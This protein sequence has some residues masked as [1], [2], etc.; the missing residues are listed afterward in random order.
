M[1]IK[2]KITFVSFVGLL[3]L[4]LVSLYLSWSSLQ[5][6]GEAEMV[7]VRATLMS[8]KKEKLK[9]LVESTQAILQSHYE[10][11]HNPQKIAAA[12]QPQLQAI[13]DVTVAAIEAINKESG[14]SIEEKKERAAALVGA[15]RYNG[16]DYLWINDMD[17]QMIMHPIKPALNGKDLSGFADPSG[18]KLFVEFVKVC[19]D[20]GAGTVEY[21]WPKPGAEQPV[22]KL[23]YVKLFEP[24]GWVI[25]TGVYLEAAEER[26]MSDAKAAIGQL[27]YGPEGAEYF[28]INDLDPAMIMHPVKPALDGKNLAGIKDPSGK[29]LFLEMVEK[30]K[31]EQGAGFVDYLWPKPG[32]DEPVA[33]LSFVKLF[34]PWGW[35]VGTGIYLDDVEA[36]VA[37]RQNEITSAIAS[38]RNR[39]IITLGL[40]LVA[41]CG[42]VAFVSWQ[43]TR[44]ISNTSA[45]LEDVAQGEGDLT[46]RLEV[47]SKDEIGQMAGWFNQFIAKLHDIVRNIAEYFET[48]S[49]SANQLLLIS[50]QMDEG[51]REL[52]GQSATVARSADEMSSNM[53]SVAA[54]SEQAATNVSIVAKSMDGMNKSVAE[55]DESA[56]KAQAITTRAV[57]ETNNASVKVKELGSVAAEIGKVTQVITDIS[58]QTNLLALN[59]TIEA[60]RAGDAGKGFA[61]VANEIKELARQTADATKGITEQIDSIQKSTSETVTDIGKIADVITEVDEIVS[62]I[63]ISVEQQAGATAE[64]TENISQ[65]SVGIAEVN[66]NVSQ[67]STFA[68]EIASD[69][70]EVNRIADTISESS[71]QV[72][73]NAKDLSKLAADLQ[74]MIGEF[75]VDRS[76]SPATEFQSGEN[77]ELIAWNDSIKVN[78]S[79]IDRQHHRL[80]DLINKLHNAMRNRVGKTVLQQILKELLDYTRQHFA[81]EEKM[82]SAAGY[83]KLTEHQKLHKK[84]VSQVQDF[85]QQ[86]ESG[87]ATVSLELM[88]F[89][90]DWLVNHIKG[91]DRQYVPSVK[92][93][94]GE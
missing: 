10:Y 8:E 30:A 62:T 1:S 23:S 82:M 14:L 90:S 55:I 71:S 34:E 25:G 74:V 11:A 88:T 70:G 47:N 69:I 27:R 91:I 68:A 72:S 26:F 57:E 9:D 58:D 46:R 86:F 5:K 3:L 33:K 85:K 17:V 94:R 19:R 73:G 60:A 54:A 15:M 65:A 2:I 29:T 16:S 59:A 49:A 4:G 35:V 92:A 61:V 76:S 18:K 38:Q 45:M 89:L 20:K 53:N 63:S 44:S 28:W 84:L 81:D 41:V 78:I 39:L 13:V 6:R 87:S 93:H 31:N 21:L 56:G 48:V 22:A 66:E 83:D 77:V 42:I 12:Y 32:F 50:N 67:S 40:L 51:L 80:V 64:I 52:C 36:A 37:A 43:I 75:K 7:S 79:E 24:W